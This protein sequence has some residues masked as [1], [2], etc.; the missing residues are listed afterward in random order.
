MRSIKS[1]LSLI[2]GVI[3]TLSLII[4]ATIGFHFNKEDLKT[5]ILQG[6][7]ENV[8]AG[9]ILFE[10]F[11][12]GHTDSLT[13]MAPFLSQIPKEIFTDPEALG[14]E[15]GNI[16]VRAYRGQCPSG[17]CGIPRWENDHK[18]PRE[19]QGVQEIQMARTKQ[20]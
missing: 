12:A 19:R 20:Q 13:K 6:E 8:A 2:V 14:A 1:K 9:Y 16:L 5:Y 17:V 4:L 3:L 15:L 11:K 18:R 10:T 7:K